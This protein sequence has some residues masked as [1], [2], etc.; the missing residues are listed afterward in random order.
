MNPT[1]EA[2][3]RLHLFAVL[4]S[5]PYGV[6]LANAEGRIVFSNDAA[7]EILGVEAD[8]DTT[9]DA[10][11]DR[12]GAF[13]PDGTTPFPTEDYP[14]IRALKGERPRGVE[15]LIR[16]PARPDGAVI[17]VSGQR[18]L[19][20]DGTPIGAAVVFE[21]VTEL[22][23]T[24][25]QKQELI[26]FIVHDIRSPL[27]S[28]VT[29]CDLIAM[30]NVEEAV[31]EDLRSIRRAAWRVHHMAQDLLDLSV[32]EDSELPLEPTVLRVA[33]LLRDVREAASDRVGRRAAERVRAGQVDPSLEVHAD[34][35]LLLRA[36]MNLV[37][38]CVK[39]GP[40][41]GTIRL[42]ATAD[43]RDAV[44][45]R[46]SDQGPGVPEHLRERIFDKYA[47]VE[48]KEGGRSSGS[49]GLGLRF[50]GVVAQA[51]GGRIWVEDAEPE[52]ASFCLE[53]P[54]HR[55]ERPRGARA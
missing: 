50:C 19:D 4:D 39:Y 20:S 54:A 14:L 26:A 33:D 52:G 3:S 7:D 16:N 22:R 24:Q 34:H 8:P 44:V 55:P 10:W 31:A 36:M 40:S 47:R 51:H 12:Y 13:L 21:D 29:T 45:L 53:L 35:G 15:M 1:F 11:A 6:T 30:D 46:V 18:L 43:G 2:F 27:T 42:D 28:I 37:D 9:P 17:S 5:L 32:A 25:A 23:R 38:N 41:D 49:R 48:R